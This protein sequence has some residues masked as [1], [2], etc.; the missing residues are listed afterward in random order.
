MR[1]LKFLVAFVAALLIIF[2]IKGI[3]IGIWL[4]SI[5]LKYMAIAAFVAWLFILFRGSDKKDTE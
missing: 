5:A 4:F 1:R 3:F 2:I